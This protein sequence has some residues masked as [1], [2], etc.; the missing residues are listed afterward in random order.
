MS[1]GYRSRRSSRQ[2]KEGQTIST[3]RMHRQD[4]QGQRRGGGDGGGGR[5][6]NRRE[7]PLVCCQDEHYA[8][9]DPGALVQYAR[10]R[11]A[12]RPSIGKSALRPKT[13]GGEDGLLQVMTGG[14]TLLTDCS[15]HRGSRWLTCLRRAYILCVG[16]LGALVSG[17]A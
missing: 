5:V 9:R 1:K 2:V 16:E 3:S 14:T 13:S 15:V 7:S 10:W 12:T 4:K 8:S 17:S 6:G 11:P